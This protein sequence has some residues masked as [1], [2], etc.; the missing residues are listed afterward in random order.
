MAGDFYFCDNLPNESLLV[1][2]FCKEEDTRDNSTVRNIEE[3]IHFNNMIIGRE[4]VY[5]VNNIT[6]SHTRI[7]EINNFTDR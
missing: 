3:I 6:V 7:R 5:N 1:G 4:L 2:T